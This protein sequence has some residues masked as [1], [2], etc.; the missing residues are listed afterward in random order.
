LIDYNRCEQEALR[1]TLITHQII[2]E[3]EL[4]WNEFQKIYDPIN[5]SY[6]D[7]RHSLT[8]DELTL[9]TFRD[10]LQAYL[11]DHQLASMLAQSYWESFCNLC[12]F[13]PGAHEILTYVSGSYRIGMITNGYGDAQRSRLRACGIDGFFH[14]LIIS[15]EVGVNKPDPLIFEMAI[16]DLKVPR[17]LVL[18][19]GDSL[20]DDYHGAKNAHIDFCYY[21]PTSKIIDKAY[22]P[23][24]QINKL[25]EL[26]DI[27]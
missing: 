1:R 3:Q 9:F 16:E 13:E 23:M 18:F 25:S 21:N 11:G 17:E 27:I 4:T 5:W 15:D 6:W 8:R 19:V 14:S 24:Y 20:N 12:Y 26:R 2:D 7:Q 10:A 22:T